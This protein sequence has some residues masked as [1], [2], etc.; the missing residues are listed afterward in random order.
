VVTRALASR[1][2]TTKIVVTDLNAAMLEHA[3]TELGKTTESDG[4]RRMLKS[5]RLKM[6]A[7][8]RLFASSAQM[9]FP[10]KERA[11][12]EA[13]RVLQPGTRCYLS[14]WDKISANHFA[15]VVTQAVSQMFQ[16]AALPRGNP[17]WAL[18]R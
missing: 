15:D 3:K 6:R 14:V 5:C 17:A 7:S 2:P 18:R 10:D 11:F 16:D 13:R 4:T 8:T 9:F 12:R 1:L